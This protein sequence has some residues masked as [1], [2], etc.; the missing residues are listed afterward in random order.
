ME[1][2]L[3]IISLKDKQSDY[4]YWMSKSFIER[5]NA[6][7]LLRNQYIKFNKDV[8]PRLQRVC[9]IVNQK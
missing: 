3:R 1:K 2:A 5:L 7:E 8:Q 4:S 9:R 6:I